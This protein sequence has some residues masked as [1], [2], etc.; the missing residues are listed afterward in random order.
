MNIRRQRKIC[1]MRIGLWSLLLAC[2]H[3]TS[4]RGLVLV[5]GASGGTGLRA[6]QGLLDTG[7]TAKDLK[8]MSRRELPEYRAAGF[9]VVQGDL[10]VPSSLENIAEGCSGCYVHSTSSDTQQLDRAE[11]SRATNLAK[12][13]ASCP[14]M[15]CVVYN[16]ATGE[17]NIE[18]ERIKQKHES[19]VAYSSVL[20]PQGIT[21]VSL[22]ANFFMEELWKKVTGRPK[23]LNGKFAFALP[24]D[25][26]LYLISVRDMGRMAGRYVQRSP[27]KE[28]TPTRIINVAGDYLSPREIAAEF[29]KAQ[30]SPC[31]HVKAPILGLIA[32]LF[33][34]DLYQIITFYQTTEEKT[35]INK[36]REEFPNDITSFRDFLEETKW[37]DRSRS[38][39]DFQR[40]DSLQTTKIE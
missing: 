21:F 37:G 20:Q 8:I 28:G 22:R 2:T 34:R 13:L 18:I 7:L 40:I 3:I 23:V 24:R 31:R 9:Q 1:K 39:E 5:V 15:K 27:T 11:F 29:A 4:A 32:R 26:G 38:Y 35:D 14:S 12:V 19:E 6:I 17:E 36:L 30:G 10:D 16:S 25:R 33:F